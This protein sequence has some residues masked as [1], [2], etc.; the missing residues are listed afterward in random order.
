[1]TEN[2]YPPGVHRA[3][4]A[5]RA[6]DD[7]EIA[8]LTKHEPPPKTIALGDGLTLRRLPSGKYAF[9]W[10]FSLDGKPKVASYGIF[11]AIDLKT[12]RARH[13]EDRAKVA[14]EGVDPV[15]VRK[16]EREDAAARAAAIAAAPSR[17][18]ETV[19]QAWIEQAAWR[20]NWKKQHRR[21]VEQSLIDHAFPALRARPIAEIQPNEVKD[22]LQIME[23]RGILETARR[24]RQRLDGIF[25]YAVAEGLSTTNPLSLIHPDA[26]PPPPLRT[27]H[28]PAVPLDELPQLVRS[29]QGYHHSG[30]RYAT[31]LALRLALLTAPR[32]SD[33]VEARMGEFA[34]G[35]WEVPAERMKKDR[36]HLV[37]LSRQAQAIVDELCVLHAH[38]EYLLPHD[39]NAHRHMTTNCLLFALYR[40]GYHSRQTVHGFRTL[41]STAANS[42][43]FN[44]DWI[45]LQLSH[46]EESD[47]RRPYNRAEYWTDRTRLMQW[48][49]D[50]LDAISERGDF[51]D[52]R[53]FRQTREVV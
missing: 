19:A 26:L 7:R 29:I 20:R 25:R 30:G 45:E 43:G 5:P 23:K 3:A 46:A 52:P 28:L 15:A 13:F 4:R 10:Q 39:R 31:G 41:F 35:R 18:F 27:K 21:N 47:S 36:P 38:C 49:A 9:Q 33:L 11:P 42:A 44:S 22:V 16:K 32:P 34:P 6:T 50:Y 53:E 8:R 24:V 2:P 37:P 14:R 17:R 51:V 12:A 48:W 1:M 40:L